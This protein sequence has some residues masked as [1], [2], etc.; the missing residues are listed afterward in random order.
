MRN[1]N[2]SMS[3]RGQGEW[4]KSSYSNAGGACVEVKFITGTVLVRDSKDK[5]VDQPVITFP[6]KGWTSFLSAVGDGLS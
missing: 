2:S 5:R 6:A 3:R 4:V 1:K